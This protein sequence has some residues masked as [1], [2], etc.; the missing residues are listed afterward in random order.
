MFGHHLM[1]EKKFICGNMRLDWNSIVDNVF[2]ASKPIADMG[3]RLENLRCRRRHYL[4][5]ILERWGK[6]TGTALDIG[7][8]SWAHHR[9]SIVTFALADSM[10]SSFPYPKPPTDYPMIPVFIQFFNKTKEE[11]KQDFYSINSVLLNILRAY[12]SI[13]AAIRS[14]QCKPNKHSKNQ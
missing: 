7:P 3:P 13:N 5:G 14:G 6:L 2:D 9:C 11:S 10:D 8:G 1:W 4:L 12:L